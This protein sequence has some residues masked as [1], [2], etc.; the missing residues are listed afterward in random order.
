MNFILPPNQS[1]TILDTGEECA[2]LN[3]FQ[4]RNKNNTKQILKQVQNDETLAFNLEQDSTLEYYF[5][6]Q[7]QTIER[8]ITFNLNAPGASAKLIGLFYLGAD[9]PRRLHTIK[10]CKR[11][12]TSEVNDSQTLSLTSTMIHHAPN[13]YGNTLI[14][15]ALANQSKAILKGMIKIA[16]H[17]HGSDDLLTERILLLSP[18]ARA[19][20]DPQLEI[21][22]DQVKA[23]HAATISRINQDQLYYLKTRGLP[24]DQSK[25]FIVDGF[26]YEIMEMFPQVI[27]NTVSLTPSSLLKRE[28]P[29]FSS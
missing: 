6:Y 20:A 5:I 11:N 19:E 7:N 2:I 27:K 14:K 23:T 4:D 29:S 21:D 1:Q 25:Q 3:S 10:N 12:A 28:G 26:L 15:G 17:A 22:A 24:K 13:T 16:K 8:N 18:K 9:Q